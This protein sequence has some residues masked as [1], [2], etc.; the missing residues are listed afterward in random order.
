MAIAL[1]SV[2][3]EKNTRVGA[4]P[5]FSCVLCGVCCAQLVGIG[6]VSRCDLALR[7]HC[8]CLLSGEVAVHVRNPHVVLCSCPVELQAREEHGSALFSTPRHSLF[9]HAVPAPLTLPA[10]PSQKAFDA[11]MRYVKKEGDKALK[12]PVPIDDNSTAAFLDSWVVLR[13]MTVP[14]EYAS[15]KQQVDLAVPMASS[16]LVLQAL[17]GVMQVGRAWGGC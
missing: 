9:S 4:L 3:G 8:D 12:L 6:C 11:Y 1:E 17:L 2:L 15:F 13:R 7:Y 10:P 5:L 14:V 16:E